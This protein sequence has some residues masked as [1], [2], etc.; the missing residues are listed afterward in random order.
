MAAIVLNQE[1]SEQKEPRREG[2][3]KCE[4]MACFDCY[5]HQPTEQQEGK[6]C[7]CE[8]PSAATAPRSPENLQVTNHLPRIHA[9]CRGS[10]F[11]AARFL[12]EM[13]SRG[14]YTPPTAPIRLIISFLFQA[15]IVLG[16]KQSADVTVPLGHSD[17]KPLG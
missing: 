5:K 14:A 2:K 17:P 9:W 8:F 7:N 12:G 1:Q 11:S 13:S 15:D 6:E 3:A 16:G 4:R 10:Q